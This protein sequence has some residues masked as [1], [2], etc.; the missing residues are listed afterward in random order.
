MSGCESGFW[1]AYVILA[2]IALI[3]VAT[4]PC[5]SNMD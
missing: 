3:D 5:I 2:F 1:I 4:A